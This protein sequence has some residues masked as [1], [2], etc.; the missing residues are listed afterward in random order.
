M[1]S[2][3][4]VIKRQVTRL[5]GSS[6]DPSLTTRPSEECPL[7]PRAPTRA[8]TPPIEVPGGACAAASALMRSSAVV[9]SLPTNIWATMSRTG[10]D[11]TRPSSMFASPGTIPAWAGRRIARPRSSSRSSKTAAPWAAGSDA[12]VLNPFE[13]LEGSHLA[14]PAF[15]ERALRGPA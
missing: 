15:T 13:V 3:R 1:S 5:P 12:G 6:P 10:G 11:S 9:L 7:P 2:S 4:P 14:K 8:I